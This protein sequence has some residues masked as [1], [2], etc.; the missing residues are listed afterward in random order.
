MDKKLLLFGGGGHCKVI[1]DSLLRKNFYTG[2]GIVDPNI[3]KGNSLLG[4]PVI[5]SDEDIA[6]LYAD[7]YREAFISLGSI[8]NTSVRKKIYSQLK[9]LQFNIATII[10]PTAE[11]SSFAKVEEGSYIGKNALVNAGA[12]IA[13]CSI[14]NTG[15]IIEHDSYIG[16]FTHV[17]PGAIVCGGVTI[18]ESVHVGAGSVIKNGIVIGDEVMIGVGSTIINNIGHNMIAY[19]N[20]QSV[21]KEK[22]DE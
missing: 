2:I 21:L 22:Q 5:G 6:D 14:V 11:V 12:S 17:A 9:A 3:K 10:D 7:G 1:I 16:S 18:G 15:A 19:G 20:H 8:G 13:A 4:I